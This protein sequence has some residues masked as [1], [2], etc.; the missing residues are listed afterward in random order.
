[1]RWSSSN[2]AKSSALAN[3]TVADRSTLS[4]AHRSPFM[5][6]LFGGARFVKNS[7][8]GIANALFRL[9]NYDDL[10]GHFQRLLTTLSAYRW[11]FESWDAILML[12]SPTSTILLALKTKAHAASQLR[13]I[14]TILNRNEG[15]NRSIKRSDL[16]GY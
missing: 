1:M 6:G 4:P 13:S 5:D 10:L 8:L 3:R 16:P 9:G 2:S 14:P 15:P 7:T 11:M 12:I